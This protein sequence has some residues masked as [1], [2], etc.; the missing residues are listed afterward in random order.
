MGQKTVW[1][2]PAMKAVR[3]RRLLGANK[4]TRKEIVDG[5]KFVYHKDLDWGAFGISPG[6]VDKNRVIHLTEPE[7]LVSFIKNHE[8]AHHH[9]WNKPAMRYM[10]F[11]TANLN[12][13]TLTA[14]SLLF[15]ALF[16]IFGTLLPFYIVAPSVFFSYCICR[17][18]EEYV[19]NREARKIL[20][21]N[22]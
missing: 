18:H 6:W 4:V 17:I 14:F 22:P 19:A 3:P 8:L 2:V 1:G 21:A 10:R 7:R 9:R 13:K 11:L 15:L 16:Y 12:M 20:G 5:I